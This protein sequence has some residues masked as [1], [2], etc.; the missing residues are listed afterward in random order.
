MPD[1]AATD[2]RTC[3]YCASPLREHARYCIKCER[4]Q[5]FWGRISGE[6]NLT[7]LIALVPILTLSYA[8]LNEKLVLPYS[9]LSA[10][11]LRCKGEVTAALNNT[12]TRDAIVEGGEATFEPKRPE[13][14]RYLNSHL[15]SPGETYSPV[16]VGAGK[17]L[18]ARFAY[19]EAGTFAELPAPELQAPQKCTYRIAFS[20]VEFG[21][22]RQT[23]DAGSCQC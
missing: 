18:V 5:N 3:R 2:V 10:T 1:A 11:V 21:G 12:G 8:F 17:A 9:R 7:S 20:V 4:F 15:N 23:I 14:D 16:V 6:I 13:F 19:S 22:R